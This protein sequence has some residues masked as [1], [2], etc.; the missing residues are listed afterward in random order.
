MELL[1][2]VINNFFKDF[3]YEVTH[4]SFHMAY[5]W[6]KLDPTSSSKY[7]HEELL[8]RKPENVH[9]MIGERDLT[10]LDLFKDMGCADWYPTLSDPSKEKVWDRMKELLNAHHH[11]SLSNTTMI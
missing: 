8:E 3:Y 10:L 6:F 4:P 7:I 5:F 1:N 9:E 11:H 2:A